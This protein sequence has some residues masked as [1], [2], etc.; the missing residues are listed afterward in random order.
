MLNKFH[1]FVVALFFFIGLA[2]GF[3]ANSLQQV[4][5]YHPV[6]CANTTASELKIIIPLV[7]DLDR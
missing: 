1:C 4:G 5:K 7:D 2:G 3:L 6:S